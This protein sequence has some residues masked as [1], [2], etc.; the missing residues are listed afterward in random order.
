MAGQLP[1][2]EV[3]GMVILSLVSARPVPDRS[4][5]SQGSTR[6]AYSIDTPSSLILT[7]SGFCCGYLLPHLLLQELLSILEVGVVRNGCSSI[8]RIAV[9]KGAHASCS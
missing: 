8:V 3:S 5:G 9:R 6:L 4:L 7:S 2:V 1:S